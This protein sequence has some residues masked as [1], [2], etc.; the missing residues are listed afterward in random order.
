VGWCR[1]K[2]RFKNTTSLK[3]KLMNISPRS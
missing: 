3:K 2:K 1:R